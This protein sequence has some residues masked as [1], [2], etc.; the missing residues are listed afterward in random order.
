MFYLFAAN[1]QATYDVWFVGDSFLRELYNSHQALQ[2]TP[3][4]PSG[5]QTAA[6]AAEIPYLQ[7]FYNIHGFFYTSLGFFK[8]AT[9]RIRSSLIDG[10][11]HEKGSKRLPRY[12]VV[13]PDK[14]LLDDTDVK[15]P[16]AKQDLAKIINWLS[17]QIDIAIIRKKLQLSEK[18]PGAVVT[19]QLSMSR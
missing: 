7:E 13:M 4:P 17:R 10:L 12:V 15:L 8:Y 14:D 11:N 3:V 5:R 6:E 19:Q 1:M 18:K 9:T 2:N 16:E